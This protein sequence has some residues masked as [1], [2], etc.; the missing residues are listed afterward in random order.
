[1]TTIDASATDRARFEREQALTPT[2]LG[3]SRVAS[4]EVHVWS[5]WLDIWPETRARL[6]ATLAVDERIR[7]AR[8]RFPRDRDRF[9][10]AHGVLRELLGRYLQTAPDR[11]RFVRD[12]FGKPH[13][14]ATYGGRLRFSLS[15]SAGLALI[16]I[17]AESDVGVDVEVLGAHSDYPELA[18]QF[19][20]AA[21]IAQ[22]SAHPD[23]RYAEAFLGCWT[24]KE[25]YVKARGRGLAI[26]LS[27]FTVPLGGDRA[28]GPQDARV[29]SNDIDPSMPWTVQTLRP[30]PGYIGAL[31]V[32]GTGWRLSR[33]EWP[34]RSG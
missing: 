28:E 25:A 1:M 24:K 23:H 2:R 27:S 18:R 21:E 20:S 26:P 15:H 6:Y 22:L 12:R 5:A 8:Y 29:T 11:I 3:P 33:W 14:G 16:A 4:N 30:A 17:A 10:A 34:M 32:A 7:S 31:A 13:L 9:I 19:F